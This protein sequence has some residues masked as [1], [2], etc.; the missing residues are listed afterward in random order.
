MMTH[1]LSE[2]FATNQR[3]LWRVAVGVVIFIAFVSLPR[4]ISQ[5]YLEAQLLGEA[6]ECQRIQN[7]YLAYYLDGRQKGTSSTE[8]HA[9]STQ[10]LIDLGYLKMDE[11]KVLNEPW[12]E[13]HPFNP[14]DSRGSFIEMKTLHGTIVITQS[15][16]CNFYTSQNTLAMLGDAQ[17]LDN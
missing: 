12:V 4:W 16:E 9:P 6:V 14:K 17:T 3:L 7:A 5:E 13:K 8:A 15:G 1:S 11:V 10:E 2:L